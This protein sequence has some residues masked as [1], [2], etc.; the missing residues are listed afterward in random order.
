MLQQTGI[1]SERQICDS[2]SGPSCALDIVSSPLIFPKNGIESLK[3]LWGA[4]VHTLDFSDSTTADP[5]AI[6]L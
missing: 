6:D 4:V 3:F 1:S 2:F 5:T